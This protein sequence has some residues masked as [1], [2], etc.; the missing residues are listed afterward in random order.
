MENTK[1]AKQKIKKQTTLQRVLG[2]IT[3]IFI[4]PLIT[5]AIV[6]GSVMIVTRVEN[7]VVPVFGVAFVRVL[8]GSMKAGGY[9]IGDVVILKQVDKKEL[10]VGDVIAFYKFQDN[11]DPTKSQLVK[12]DD[13]AN[14]PTPTSNTS[15][16]GTKTQKDA[17]KAEASIIFHRIIGVYQASDGTR[18]FETK[19]DSNSSPDTNLIREEF[20]VGKD[21][22]TPKS[23]LRIFAFCFSS[24]GIIFLVI[25]PL[26]ILI[27]VQ[28]LE[29]FE[30]I[31]A[32]MVEKKVLALEIPFDSEDSIKNNIGFEM[33][34]FD[35]I[36][37]YDIMPE[38]R[39]EDVKDFLWG[40]LYEPQNKSERKQL[41]F[42]NAGLALYANREDYWD[43]FIKNT[44]FSRAKKKLRNLQ[45]IANTVRE[46]GKL[47]KDPRL[48]IENQKQV[49]K[50]LDDKKQP[51]EQKKF[52]KPK[53]PQTPKRPEKPKQSE[54]PNRPQMPKQV[55]EPRQPE[56]TKQPQTPNRPEKP[57]RHKEQ[58]VVQTEREDD[59]SKSNLLKQNNQTKLPERPKA[60]N[61]KN[62]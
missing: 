55:K 1:P 17:I 44:K 22:G 10:E 43:Y 15:V 36:Y 23:I 28:L 52:E 46:S 60:K 13:T 47:E 48:Q 14:P 27:F 37:F 18:F 51:E 56:T 38:N 12:V 19:G 11:F 3:D 54:I 16:C 62:S 9:N 42:V 58:Q 45:R 24:K 59:I 21:I 39:K 20:V 7:R 53:Q 35:K 33:R 2:I 4:Y 5:I 61:D 50:V 8:S 49:K 29:I 6:I 34:D 30:L 40:Y 25:I 57:K 41:N 26:G 32:L 31:F